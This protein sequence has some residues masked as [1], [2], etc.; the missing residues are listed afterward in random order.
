VLRASAASRSNPTPCSRCCYNGWLFVPCY[1]RSGVFTM[2]ELGFTRRV[3]EL[4]RSSLS[5]AAAWR[6]SR[7]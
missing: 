4:Y 1:V 5:G 7:R 2:P 3:L 6:A